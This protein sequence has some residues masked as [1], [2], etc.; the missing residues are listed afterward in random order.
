MGVGGAEHEQMVIAIFET[1]AKQEHTRLELLQRFGQRLLPALALVL[2][3]HFLHLGLPLPL[4]ADG[5]ERQRAR[6]CPTQCID[7]GRGQ[8][9]APGSLQAEEGQHS[10]RAARAA[11]RGAGGEDSPH[12]LTTIMPTA[13]VPQPP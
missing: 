1:A 6:P 13:I 11:A 10:W 5:V 7:D 2:L 3:L 9:A 12:N 8:R 4:R